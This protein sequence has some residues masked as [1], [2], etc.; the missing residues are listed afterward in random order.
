MVNIET[1]N[2]RCPVRDRMLVEIRCTSCFS[3]ELPTVF[4]VIGSASRE[5]F[6][7][8]YVSTNI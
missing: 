3:R 1:V 5:R 2:E 6:R 7:G 8:D 4:Q